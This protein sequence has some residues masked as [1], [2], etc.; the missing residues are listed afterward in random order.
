M[1]DRDTQISVCET[2][3]ETC[4]E[5]SATAAPPPKPVLTKVTLLTG[6]IDRHY[7]LGLAT[8]LA[9]LGLKVEVLGA[10]QIDCPSFHSTPGI[11]FVNL[12]PG[13]GTRLGL[14]GKV[15]SLASYYVRLLKYAATAE[16]KIFHILWN[17]KFE[18]FD[19]TLLMLYYKLLGKK[20]VFTAH[21][22]NTKARDGRDSII[23]RLTLGA[24]YHLTDKVFAHTQKMKDELCSEFGLDESRTVTI[25]YPINDAVPVT[26]LG[27]TEARR[28]LGIRDEE[29]AVLFFGNLR[30]SKGLEYLVSAV[31]ILRSK[32]ARYRLIIAGEKKPD[33]KEYVDVILRQI[34]EKRMEDAVIERIEYIP[35]EDV[36]IYFKA[37]DVLALPYTAIFQSG[38]L[39]LG[40]S[41][42][43]P[44]VASD[45]GSIRSDVI[46]GK[47][48]FVCRPRDSLALAEAIDKYFQSDLYA[49]L[50]SRRRDIATQAQSTHSWKSVAETT[51]AVY[52]SLLKSGS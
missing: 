44:A 35:D 19:R 47:T 13:T 25:S 7:S 38:I 3:L 49:N 45:V 5:G 36:E 21:N 23:N 48:G 22:V 40:L 34:R 10:S 42:G 17:N 24:Q 31:E 43:L 41:F 39:F 51:A 32:D 28:A 15:W 46:E 1:R 52:A 4:N 6:G 20:I 30:P 18:A 27:R 26:S 29:R 2:P 14:L 50:D 33:T 11:R 12:R 8:A 16:P 37:S 9:A